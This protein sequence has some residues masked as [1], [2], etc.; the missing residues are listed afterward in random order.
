M[1]VL[2]ANYGYILHAFIAL[3]F[4]D[5]SLLILLYNHFHHFFYT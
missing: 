5:Y 4:Y 3:Y 2:V 1:P